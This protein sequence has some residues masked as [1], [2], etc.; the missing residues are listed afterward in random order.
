MYNTKTQFQTVN[1]QR[2]Q[3]G[4]KD[5]VDDFFDRMDQEIDE[6]YGE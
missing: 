2:T 3:A 6:I 5:E 4:F 1:S